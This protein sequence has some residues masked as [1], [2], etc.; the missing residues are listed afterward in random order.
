MEFQPHPSVK[1]KPNI[2]RF[3]CNLRVIHNLPPSAQ[4]TC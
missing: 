2:T 1:P 3:A 4:L